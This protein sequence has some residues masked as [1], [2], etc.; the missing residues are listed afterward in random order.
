MKDIKYPI[1]CSCCGKV[2]AETVLMIK[3]GMAFEN[4]DKTFQ[5]LTKLPGETLFFCHPVCMMEYPSKISPRTAET[6]KSQSI[7]PMTKEAE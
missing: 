4:Q 1:S 2:A 5:W 6:W 7:L 3:G